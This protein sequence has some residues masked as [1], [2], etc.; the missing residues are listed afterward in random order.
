MQRLAAPTEKTLINPKRGEI[1]LV[2]FD[3]TRS[4]E[5]GKTRPALVIQDE[6]I[7]IGTLI[8]IP[9]STNIVLDS[10]PL[11]IN[12]SLKFL[13]KNSDLAITQMRSLSIGRFRKK[14]GSLPAS[15]LTKISQY[16]ALILSLK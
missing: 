11:R 12:Y 15:E 2:D 6:R 10:E 14:L 4:D 13:D 3:P 1:W 8:V 16:I 7:D 9:F 5:I